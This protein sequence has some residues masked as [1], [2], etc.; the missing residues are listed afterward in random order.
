MEAPLS[1]AFKEA[2]VRQLGVEGKAALALLSTSAVLWALAALFRLGVVNIFD[3]YLMK[4]PGPAVTFGAMALFPLAA[5][6]LGLRL[7]RR[8]ASR[9]FGQALTAAGAVLTL[10]TL[11]FIGLPLTLEALAPRP[12]KNPATPRPLPPQ[13]GLPVFPGAEGFGTRTPAGRGGKVIQVTSLADHGPGT[14]RAALEDPA[15][16]IIVFRVGG[17]IELEEHLYIRHPYVTV[18]GQT[19]PGD[20]VTL[21]NGGVVILTHDVLL[22]HLRIRPGNQGPVDPETNDAATILGPGGGLE[23]AYNVVLDHISASWGED[24]T[25][26]IWAGAHDV[27]ISWSIIAEG[28]RQ[29]RHPKG[30]HSAGLLIGDRSYNV[31]VHHTLLA[32]N[33][34]RN[35]L[36]KEGG[37]HDFVNNVVYNWGTLAV[38]VKADE[39]NTFLNFVGNLFLPGPS[40][41][42]GLYEI[43]L[44]ENIDPRLYLAGNL[45]P[46]RPEGSL[47]EWALVGLGYGEQPAPAHPFRS[48]AP[49]P[50][51]PVT[52]LPAQEALDL[53]LTQA[54]ATRPVR[55][56]VDERIVQEARLGT[57]R[58]IDSPEDV[59]GYPWLESGQAPP[60]SDRDGMPDAWEQE[61][62][63]NPHDPADA[64]AD[65]DGDG[66]T[67]IEAY[68]H[69]LAGLVGD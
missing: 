21:K 27:T 28:L 17:T 39:S 23:G 44:E 14:L 2:S 56:P 53:V 57:G 13:T 3:R 35:P 30:A 47:D 63:L 26:S 5:G 12:P 66:Y 16:R 62:G 6:L 10:A 61:M 41:K 43:I 46:H 11:V 15:P 9:T 31:S 65:L 54:G 52:A 29:S 60:D 36:V 8:S 40:T 22:Q 45:G 49:F 59:G 42:A 58:I 4:F 69:L 55:D 33:D 38:E 50:A 1:A 64:T 51:P 68:L 37:T 48:P 19:A 24:E 25:V 20:G 34:I 67:N 18:A 32:H 7:A